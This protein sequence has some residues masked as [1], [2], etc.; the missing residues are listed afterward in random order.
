MPNKYWTMIKKVSD[1]YNSMTYEERTKTKRYCDSQRLTDFEQLK[2]L[3]KRNY[4]RQ[5]REINEWEENIYKWLEKG[6]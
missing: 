6:E 3:L 1:E 4:I 5:M 2:E